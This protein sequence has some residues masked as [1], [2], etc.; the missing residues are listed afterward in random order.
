MF[1]HNRRCEARALCAACPVAAICLWSAMAAE[2]DEEYRYGMAGEAWGLSSASAWPSAPLDPRP[3][4]SSPRPW[5]YGTLKPRPLRPSRRGA[6]GVPAYRPWRK[7]R[8]CKAV[9]R[10]A[11]AGR[12]R[13]WCSRACRQRATRDRAAD[14]ARNRGRWAALPESVRDQ[15]RAAMRARW[16]PSA[17]SCAPSWPPGAG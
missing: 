1:N 2:V 3:T 8:G 11:R 10:Q 16:G 6:P 12:P 5:R 17:P 14:A 15:R 9:I 13:L 7:C 4:T